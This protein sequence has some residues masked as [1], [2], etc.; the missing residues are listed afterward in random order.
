MPERNRVHCFCGHL[1]GGPCQPSLV[2]RRPLMRMTTCVHEP[3]VA[4]IGGVCFLI[5]LWAR[6][7]GG[8]GVNR[9]IPIFEVLGAVIVMFSA[10]VR[11]RRPMSMF[12]DVD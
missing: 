9:T 6:P 10:W 4:P 12:V 3:H 7:Q 2:K 8:G 11:G 1:L 5:R